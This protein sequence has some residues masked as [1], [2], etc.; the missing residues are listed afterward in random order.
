MFAN[1]YECVSGPSRAVWVT[2]ELEAPG[3]GLMGL[4]WHP[5]QPPPSPFCH[6]HCPGGGRGSQGLRR[7]LAGRNKDAEWSWVDL[8][9]AG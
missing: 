4:P 9:E 7:D 2:E 1:V 8:E 3:S 5:L 6:H